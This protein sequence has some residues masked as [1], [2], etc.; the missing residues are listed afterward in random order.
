MSV[1]NKMLRDLDH[2]ANPTATVQSGPSSLGQGTA[3]VSF[4]NSSFISATAG[5]ASRLWL[6]LGGLAVAGAALG[7]WLWW[8]ANMDAQKAA[9]VQTA[10][11]APTS[12]PGPAPTSAPASQPVASI[13]AASE[14]KT[15]EP[16]IA[17]APEPMAAGVPMAPA[18][19]SLR[20][21]SSLSA[22]KA[23]DALRSKSANAR[24]ETPT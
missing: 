17:S 20:M 9:S 11:V 22:R 10:A 4:G 5:V 8:S 13:R 7:G 1:I 23:L 12:E 14:P 15:E 18:A 21:E 19:A 6:G 16:G 3:S 2:R 24:P